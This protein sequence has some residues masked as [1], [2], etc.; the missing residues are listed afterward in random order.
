M[1]IV[2]RVDKRGNAYYIDKNTGKRKSFMSYKLS[3]VKTKKPIIIKK[4]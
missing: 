3:V 2:K 4:H 1:A